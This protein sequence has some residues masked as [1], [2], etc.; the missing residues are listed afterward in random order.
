MRILGV[1]PG[2]ASTGWGVVDVKE[3]D[4]LHVNHGCIQTSKTL[5]NSDRFL[6]IYKSINEIIAS[7]KPEIS[8]IEKLYFAKNAKSAMPV[9]EARGV[10]TL[11]LAQAGLEVFEFTPDAIKTA[12]TGVARAD[13]RQVQEMV[14][15]ILG[16]DA[17][18]SPDHAADAL[19]SAICAANTRRI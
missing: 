14:R 3:G 1:D 19:A 9:G 6:F 12:V 16:L 15:I 7:Y 2:L 11:A 8:A 18:P 10:L 13:K 17:P 4:I 5:S